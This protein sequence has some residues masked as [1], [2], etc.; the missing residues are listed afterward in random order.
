M[1]IAL[2][3][4]GLK[5]E[6]RLAWREWSTVTRLLAIGMPAFIA[7][8]ALFGAGAMGLSWGAAIVLAAALAPTDPVLAGDIGVGPPGDDDEEHEPH[9]GVSA[10][11][12][13]NDGLAFPFVLLG[14]AVAEGSSS[15]VLAGLGR[16][17]TRCSA[18]SRWAPGSATRS[19]R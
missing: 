14:I 11:A 18:A 3:S 1:V 6:R 15:G 4:T 17:C 19:P 8:A 10:E 16:A 13:F 7:L 9:F 2:F 12:G 5:L